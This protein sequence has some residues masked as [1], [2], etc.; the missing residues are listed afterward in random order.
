ML[1]ASTAF[2]VD[3]V[4][5]NALPVVTYTERRLTS[6]VGVTHTPAPAGASMSLPSE[7]VPTTFAGSGMVY[8][9]QISFPVLA[10]SAATSPR[11]VQHA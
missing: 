3:G 7:F 2:E 6:I 5:E 8:V 11:N 1:K 4:P 9:F 10:S